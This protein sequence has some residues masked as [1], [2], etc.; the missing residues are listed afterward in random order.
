MTH[1]HNG[2]RQNGR[3]KS[4][5][6]DLKQSNILPLLQYT[7]ESNNS[8]EFLKDEQQ[9]ELQ[10]ASVSELSKLKLKSNYYSAQNQIILI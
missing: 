1:C 10:K 9:C 5:H 2:W 8:Q 6:P 4:S 3:A 7:P